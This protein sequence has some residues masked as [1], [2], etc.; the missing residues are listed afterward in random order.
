MKELIQTLVSFFRELFAE[1]T[2]IGDAPYPL[3]QAEWELLCAEEAMREPVATVEE[4]DDEEQRNP[5][6]TMRWGGLHFG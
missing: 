2:E 6:L 5:L 4:L 1:T 3:T